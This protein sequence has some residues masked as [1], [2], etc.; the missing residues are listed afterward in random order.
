[1]FLSPISLILEKIIL[2]ETVMPGFHQLV[3]NDLGYNRGGPDGVAQA[4]T[5]DQTF[6]NK[7]LVQRSITI[8]QDQIGFQVELK[9]RLFHG[10]QGSLED[11]QSIDFPGPKKPQTYGHGLLLDQGEEGIPLLGG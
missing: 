9:N 3:S 7:R 4:V 2:R 5:L 1:M 8:D 6:L 11:I 10:R